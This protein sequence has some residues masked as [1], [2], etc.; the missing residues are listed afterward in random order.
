MT[1]VKS[2]PAPYI[3]TSTRLRVRKAKLLPRDDYLRMQ[4]MSLP[5]IAR[6]IG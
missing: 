1:E 2:G 6:F 5:E 4:N 3:Y